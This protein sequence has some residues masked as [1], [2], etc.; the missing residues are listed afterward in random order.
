MYLLLIL[1]ISCFCNS[2]KNVQMKTSQTI[3]FKI[4]IMIDSLVMV[5]TLSEVIFVFLN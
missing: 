5:W 4:E 2:N 3:L 1:F